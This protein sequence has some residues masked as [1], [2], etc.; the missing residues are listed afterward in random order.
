MNNISVSN[1]PL[2]N[3]V[4][5]DI[6]RLY[7]ALAKVDMQ[8]FKFP[9][10]DVIGWLGGN[11]DD[12]TLWNVR[13]QFFHSVEVLD[14]LSAAVNND[15]PELRLYVSTV[16]S[17]RAQTE[18]EMTV[19]AYSVREYKNKRYIPN[20]YGYTYGYDF[21]IDKA[22]SGRVDRKEVYMTSNA[23]KRFTMR[24]DYPMS[25]LVQDYY[26][27]LERRYIQALRNSPEQN[28]QALAQIESDSASLQEALKAKDAQICELTSTLSIK[29]NRI[30]KLHAAN[31]ELEEKALWQSRLATTRNVNFEAL[32]CQDG[33]S[34]SDSLMLSILRMRMKPV[35]LYIVNPQVVPHAEDYDIPFS[36]IDSMYDTQE[37]E[38][39]F[40]LAP[41]KGKNTLR[42]S[43]MHKPYVQLRFDSIAHY[44]AAMPRLME[45][46]VHGK[47]I[48]AS[49]ELINDIVTDAFNRVAQIR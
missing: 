49:L 24:Q 21:V 37:K 6:Y 23:F 14:T 40:E 44:D 22:Q 35:Q 42:R 29:D 27:D 31:A 8:G 18:K 4:Q 1:V 32:R 48:Y 43:R 20:R 30:R 41:F 17:S 12:R 5:E 33:S 39:Y 9:L 3:A 36:M 28:Q 16:D 46:A 10:S 26:L 45:E 11:T 13:N 19:P 2:P 15:I 47:I 7:M 34:N 38:H 25:L